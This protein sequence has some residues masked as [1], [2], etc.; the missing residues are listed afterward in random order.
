M[1]ELIDGPVTVSANAPAR[2]RIVASAVADLRGAPSDATGRCSAQGWRREQRVT[3]VFI[4]REQERAELLTG[5]HDTV[6]GHGRLFLIAGGAGIG[7]TALAQRFATDAEEH[8]LRVLRGRCWEGGGAPP[9][10]PWMQIIQILADGCDD[11][12]LRSHLGPGSSHL[13]RMVPAVAQRLG[14]PAAPV[15]SHGSDAARFYLFE[16]T[17]RFLRR[18]ASFERLMLVLD[19]LHVADAASL[20]LL[21]FL[22]R[23]IGGSRLL[24]VATYRDVDAARRPD[25]VD[26]LGDLAREG[27]VLS[28]QRWVA[29]TSP[30]SSPACR[31]LCPGSRRWRRSTT[32]PMVTRCLCGR[33]C[34]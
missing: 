34:A 8:G 29:T 7:K 6:D 17:A 9:Y 23:D 31:G 5:L 2:Q 1:S 19:D 28:P 18:A 11:E 20:L 15:T 13:A 16:A 32:R 3:R 22:T 12:T 25:A 10:W 30:T 24:V 26:T 21:R 4:G 27:R 33:S 14:A